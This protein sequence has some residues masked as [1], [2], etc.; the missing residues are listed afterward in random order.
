MISLETNR[1]LPAYRKVGWPRQRTLMFDWS[2][3]SNTQLYKQPKE[4]H[5]HDTHNT[6]K[7]NKHSF[8]SS[9]PWEPHV[10]QQSLQVPNNKKTA[11][12][13]SFHQLCNKG[14]V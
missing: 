6:K 14:L 2:S 11:H 1:D 5:S 10:P 8:T 12:P 3:N 9:P 4:I 13:K 7:H